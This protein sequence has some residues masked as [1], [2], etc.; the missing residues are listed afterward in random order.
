MLLISLLARLVYS[1]IFFLIPTA[2]LADARDPVNYQC[3]WKRPGS[4]LPRLEE[5]GIEELN[6]LQSSGMVTSV[7]LVHARPS[8][9]SPVMLL[10]AKNLK[11]YIQRTNEVN[12][13]LRAVGEINPDALLIARTLDVERAAGRVRG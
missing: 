13:I 7:D 6:Y 4:G 12:S 11:A 9:F 1:Y 5:A 3:S 8:C 10:F 2:S